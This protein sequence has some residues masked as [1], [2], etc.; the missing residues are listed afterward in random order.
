MHEEVGLAMHSSN[1][2]SVSPAGTLVGWYCCAVLL[3]AADNT[4]LQILFENRLKSGLY[5]HNLARTCKMT[6]D[7]TD[8]PINEPQPFNKKWYSHKFKSAGLRYEVGV[9]LQSGDICWVNGPFPCGSWSDLKIF[10]SKLANRL[11]PG[12]MV[13]ADKGYPH[14]KVRTPRNIVSQTD[15]RAKSKARARHETVNKRFKQWSCLTQNFRHELWKH[16]LC[17]EAVVVCTQLSFYHGEG[18]FPITY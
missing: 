12:E 11:L 7:G 13:E 3:S 10:K 14:R 5:G 16:R 4:A 2:R 17:F 15:K 8:C 18:P 9:G 6:V 1:F